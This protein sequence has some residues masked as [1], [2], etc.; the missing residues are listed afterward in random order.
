[1]SPYLFSVFCN[2]MNNISEF[3]KY[4]VGIIMNVRKIFESN[5]D[6][7][8][9]AIVQYIMS[10]TRILPTIMK[11]FFQPLVHSHVAKKIVK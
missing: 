5:L 3:L 11:P 10:L 6:S 7:S 9:N 1:M 4:V 2:K 8:I